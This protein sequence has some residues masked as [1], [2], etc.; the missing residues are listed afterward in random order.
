[1]HPSS[2]A[3][4]CAEAIVPCLLIRWYRCRT[5]YCHVTEYTEESSECRSPR[6]INDG[7]YVVFALRRPP[8]LPMIEQVLPS[9][10]DKMQ[11]AAMDTQKMEAE[12]Y[13]GA[14]QV[15]GVARSQRTRA[16]CRRLSL[17]IS[18]IFTCAIPRP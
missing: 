17:L 5:A 2:Q 12:A 1:M 6:Q 10:R 4:S 3:P 11:I 14:I 9:L 7:D 15:C 8:C 13:L 16:T 18:A